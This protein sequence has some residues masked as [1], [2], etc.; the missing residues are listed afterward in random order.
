MGRWIKRVGHRVYIFFRYWVAG[1]SHRPRLLWG[2]LPCFNNIKGLVCTSA[3]YPVVIKTMQRVENPELY[4]LFKIK[5]QGVKLVHGLASANIITLFHGTRNA[6]VE[7]I[8]SQGLNRNFGAKASNLGRAVYAT[9]EFKKAAKYAK[10]DRFGDKTIIVCKGIAGRP[11]VATSSCP[12]PP[13]CIPT[14]LGPPI[15][16]ASLS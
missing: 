3:N 5:E 14:L 16:H 1:T 6:N 9:P 7:S 13:F 10:A 4:K 12:A 8:A 15:R 11:A 2:R